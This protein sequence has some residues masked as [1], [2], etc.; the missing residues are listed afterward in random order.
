ML[1]TIVYIFTG[2]YKT[3]TKE[4]EED[5]EMHGKIVCTRELEELIL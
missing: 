4:T 3:L 2:N 1:L 5:I